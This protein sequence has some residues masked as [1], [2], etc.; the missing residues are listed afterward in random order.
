[1]ND[2]DGKLTD[3]KDIDPV[4]Y[5]KLFARVSK[6]QMAQ[7]ISFAKVI[8]GVAVTVICV[9]LVLAITPSVGPGA[10]IATLFASAFFLIS[11]ASL[12]SYQKLEKDFYE[13]GIWERE[14]ASQGPLED[15]F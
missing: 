2:F 3:P 5:G 4:K 14:E 1:M 15:P 11:H 8:R 12:R 9:S 10:L 7:A 13:I 6:R